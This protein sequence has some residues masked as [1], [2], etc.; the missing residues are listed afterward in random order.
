MM[1][2]TIKVASLALFLVSTM[3]AEVNAQPQEWWGGVSYQGALPGGDTKLM[4]DGFSWRGIG[5][6]GRTSVRSN[7]S[8]G[9]F[10][11]WN[12]FN[13]EVDGTISVAGADVSGFQSRFVNAV[14]LLAT[15][16]VYSGS[17]GGTRAYLGGGIGTYWVENRLELG[18]TALTSSNWH[19]GLAPEVGIILPKESFAAGFLSIKYNYAFESGGLA[20]SYW[21]FGIGIAG[22][23]RF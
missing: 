18:Q 11:G 22:S 21:T 9:A 15:A 17:K 2:N 10:V 4:A 19:F 13:D 6:E 3:A 16:H 20:H 14:P 1:R 8:V 7:L 23:N 12:V 5:L